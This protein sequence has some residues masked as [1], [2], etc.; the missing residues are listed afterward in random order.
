MGEIVKERMRKDRIK[1]RDAE[2]RNRKHGEG[3]SKNKFK[4]VEIPRRRGDKRGLGP[5]P[6]KKHSG[7][8]RKGRR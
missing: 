3:T 6:K 5:P 2:R 7:G 8:G 4:T 1:E